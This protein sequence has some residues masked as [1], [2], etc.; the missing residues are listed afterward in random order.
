[1]AETRE[2]WI[3]KRAYT[4]WEEEGYPT[5]R[6]SIHWEQARYE[7]EALEG[8]AASSNGKEAK[9]KAK[10]SVTGTK[11]NGV[12]TPTAKRTASRKTAS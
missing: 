2:E 5:G 8:S 11:S 12:V 7:R 6:D 10:R 9:P 4:L 1:M 3:K